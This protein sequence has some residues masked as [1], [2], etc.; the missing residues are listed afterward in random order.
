MQKGI[1]FTFALENRLPAPAMAKLSKH[2]NTS[3]LFGRIGYYDGHHNILRE[4]YLELQHPF[5]EIS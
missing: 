5:L 3:S 1:P 2:G 4:V